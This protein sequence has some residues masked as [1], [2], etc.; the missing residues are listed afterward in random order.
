MVLLLLAAPIASIGVGATPPT[1]GDGDEINTV[2]VSDDVNVWTRSALPLRTVTTNAE[3]KIPNAEW[4]VSTDEGTKPLNK[5]TLGVYNSGS[6]IT[7]QF[8]SLDVDRKLDNKN[9]HL[10]AARVSPNETPANSSEALDLLNNS[11]GSDL[12]ENVAFYSADKETTDDDGHAKLSFDPE[13]SGRYVLFLAMSGETDKENAGLSVD[14]SN[15]LTVEEQTTIVGVENALVQEE[16]SN[17]IFKGDTSGDKPDQGDTL[18][19]DV[20]NT[21]L[22]GNNVRHA[23]L[24]YDDTTGWTYQEFTL[25]VSGDPSNLTELS[26]NTTLEHSVDAVGGVARADDVTLFGQELDGKVT[27]TTPSIGTLFDFVSAEAEL[28]ADSTNGGKFLNASVTAKQGD[29]STIEVETLDNWPKSE[30]YRWVHVAVNESG[31]METDTA[32]FEFE[33]PDIEVTDASLNTSEITAGERVEVTAQLKN[34]GEETG[35]R[36]ITLKREG[37]EVATRDVTLDPGESSTVTF[38]HR[39]SETGTYD[40]HVDWTYAGE[41]TVEA[42][43]DDGGNNNNGGGGGSIAG[44]GPALSVTT[45]TEQQSDGS[46]LADVRNAKAGS[47]VRVSIPSEQA[48]RVSGV[49]FEQL[50]IELAN[51][52]SHFELSINTYEQRPSSV[53]S[54]PAGADVKGYIEV[55]KRLITNDD[56]GQATFDFRVSA[57]RLSEHSSPKNVA[58]YRY[59]DGSWDELETRFVRQDG[60]EYVFEAT[61][62][63]FSVFAVGEKQP[64]ISVTNAELG[65]S[66]VTVGETVTVTAEVSNDGSGEGTYTTEFVVDGEVVKR[67]DV[68][69]SAGETETVTFEYTPSETGEYSVAISDES[70]GILTVTDDG[71]SGGDGTTETTSE[72]GESGEDDDDVSLIG[73]T[74]G[75]LVLLGL[76]AGLLYYFRDEVQRQ[77]AELQR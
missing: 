28:T 5:S 26:E 36:T 19:F 68:T 55:E 34:T 14:N 62:P 47:T 70:A 29:V 75:I 20:S 59:H 37:T 56:I 51:D 23:V 48:T 16:S 6:E 30:R 61:T 45:E 52:N 11:S 73:I 65:Q 2:E 32:G 35:K 74:V 69:V 22:K 43:S 12:N 38:V 3:T 76:V 64:D 8:R 17:V 40:F 10:V 57:D 72:P 46:V 7:V 42:K 25:S 27:G 77:L 50:G 58:L 53:A 54:D 13:Q 67:Q 24:V 71:S 33:D 31:A 4:Y 41:L 15:N 18:K 66:S 1:D 63:G 39:V 9:V 60:S 44:G 49:T 21:A